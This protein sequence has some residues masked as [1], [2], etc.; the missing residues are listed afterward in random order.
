[1]KY[2]HHKKMHG[3]VVRAKDLSEPRWIPPIMR[4]IIREFFAYR[5]REGRTFLMER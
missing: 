1:M 4:L 2:S 3:E 5:S